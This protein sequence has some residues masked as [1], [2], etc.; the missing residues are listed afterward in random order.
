MTRYASGASRLVVRR[1]LIVGLLV[2]G[3]CAAPRRPL[4]PDPDLSTPSWVHQSESWRKLEAIEAWLDEGGPEARPDLVPEA[5]LLLAEGRL[6][7][8]LAERDTL[9]A[10]VLA[11]RLGAAERDFRRVLANS[12]SS[13]LERQR[14]KSG[15]AKA[16]NVRGGGATQL[17]QVGILP[18][19]TWKATGAVPGRLTA[20]RGPYKRITVHHSTIP[21]RDL[22]SAPLLA[23][24]EAVRDIQ[25]VHMR[26]RSYGD[27]GYHF[28]IGP[29][30]RV[31]AGRSLSYQ[32]AHSSG[33]NNIANVGICLLGHYD[34]ERPTTASLRA[35]ESLIGELSKRH[36]IP[37]SRVFGHQELKATACPGKN[38]MAWVERYR[39][40]VAMAS[41]PAQ[42]KAR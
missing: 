35:L 42:A 36:R 16:Q 2:L 39:R 25:L 21:I 13:R 18:R 38:L 41:T 32:G 19:S 10:G 40:N 27:I 6:R 11:V 14:A 8:A 17:G 29:K 1:S 7:F 4:D 5:R 31:F 33:A 37:R 20:H 23:V 22:G 28:L 3:A 12:D 30:G 24:A 15:L 34:H 26:D 9:P